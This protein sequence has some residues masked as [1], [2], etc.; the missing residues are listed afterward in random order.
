MMQEIAKK[1]EQK[2]TGLLRDGPK[3]RSRR[4]SKQPT[5][6]PINMNEDDDEISLELNGFYDCRERIEDEMSLFDCKNENYMT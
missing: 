6:N 3:S 4:I 2:Y 5:I 1:Q